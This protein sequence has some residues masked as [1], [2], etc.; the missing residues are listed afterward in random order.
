MHRRPRR[1]RAQ[2]RQADETFVPRRSLEVLTP[3]FAYPLSHGAAVRMFHPLRE[4]AREF[5]VVVYAFAEGEIAEADLKPVLEFVV[6][7]YLVPKPRYR[8]PR[9]S[10]LLPPEVGEYR[11]PE[12]ERLL[13]SRQTDL[14]Q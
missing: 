2:P 7:V 6:R 11:S 1:T 9:W 8:E 5:G 10:T 13:R 12:M 4:A 14:L 3:Y